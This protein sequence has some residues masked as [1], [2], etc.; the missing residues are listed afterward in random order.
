V[1]TEFRETSSKVHDLAAVRIIG[2]K[3][4]H[5]NEKGKTIRNSLADSGRGMADYLTAVGS[6]P[7]PPRHLAHW[8]NSMIASIMPHRFDSTAVALVAASCPS[9]MLLAEGEKCQGSG[10]SIPGGSTVQDPKVRKNRMSQKSGHSIWFGVQ[11]TCLQIV[12]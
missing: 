6:A 10:H 8:A 11:S 7:Q 2:R 1:K 5:D 4:A 12:A 3:T 9:T